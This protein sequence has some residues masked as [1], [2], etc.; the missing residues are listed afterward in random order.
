MKPTETVL[1]IQDTFNRPLRDLR[2]SVTDRCNFRCSYCMPAEIFH[3]RFQFLQREKLLTYEEITRLVK[4]ILRLGAVKLRLTGGEPLVRQDI[5]VLVAQL[6]QLDGVEDLAMTTNAFLLGKKAQQLKDAGLRRLTISLDSLDNDVFRAMNGGR[7]DVDQV[8][9]GIKAAQ[10]VGFDQIKINMVVQRGINDHTMVDVAR[11]CRDEGH[12]LRF[13]EYMDVGTM[14]GWKLDD[15]VPAKEIAERIH[16]AFPL[17]RVPR[18]YKSETAL[19]FAYADGAGEIGIIASVT[20][21]F[22]G[23]CSRMRLSPEG[24]IF[25]CLFAAAGTDLKTPLRDGA[26]DDEIEQIIRDTWGS[27]IDR[28]SEERTALANTRDKVEMY[29]IG[30]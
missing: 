3:E 6:S 2:I 20:Q 21:P 15:V 16:D 11:W 29:Y 10:N 18:N 26:S 1:P 8:L 5:E 19:R 13:I 25:T 22:C 7:A 30:G 14:N 23:N 12:I 27:R 4:V 17:E 9:A 28:Y 24:Q